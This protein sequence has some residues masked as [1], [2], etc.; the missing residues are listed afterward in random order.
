M[1]QA[2][3]RH[4]S[5]TK[6]LVALGSNVA[7]P[8]GEPS[9]TVTAAFSAIA[10]DRVAVESVSRLFSTPCVPAGAGPDYVNAAARLATTLSAP[11]LLAHLHQIE[12]R[13][14]RQ[15][16]ARWGARTLDLDLLD[17]GRCVVP[18]A[19]TWRAWQ[20]LPFDR[21]TSLTP[22]R[23][24]LPHP[25]LQDR[26]FVLL[27]LADVAPEWVHPVLGRSVAEMCA[28]LT[29]A[30]R[31]GIVMLDSARSLALSAKGQ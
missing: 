31:S 2:I 20:S 25:R 8:I 19:A 7:S 18:D 24:I 30:Q 23:L 17:Y 1:L 10:S 14:E 13:F 5:V 4:K 6:A 21:Q 27:P 12:A 22:D 29:A 3:P 15:R 28:G 16:T 9:Q 11:E 26:A